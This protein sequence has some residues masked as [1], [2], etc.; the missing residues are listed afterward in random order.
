MS[1]RDL[2]RYLKINE[3]KIYKLVQEGKVP[4]MK[5]GGK[6]AFVRELIDK[7]ILGNTEWEQQLFV[8]GSDDILLRNIIDAY[9]SLHGGLVFYAP[10][11]SINGLKALQ[12]SKATMSCVHILESAKKE[13]D[14]S[15]LEK[16]LGGSEY[17]V[18]QLFLREQGLMVPKG[19]PKVI[20]SLQ[21]ITIKG[22]G[23]VNRNQGSGTR[24]LLDF[25]LREAKIEPMSLK[26]YGTEVDT[27]IQ[28][29]LSVLKGLADVG[30]GIRHVAHML[31]LDFVFLFKE[32]FDVVIP[33][34]R[35]YSSHVKAFLAFCEQSA[36]L[37]NV[38]DFTGYDLDKMG[39]VV[40]PRG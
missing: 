14:V 32:R 11:G 16:Y 8:A 7:W 36:L 26:G 38:R 31:G 3:K 5:I 23:F 28:V 20:K 35:Y 34:E 30:F 33:K 27:H 21:D 9:N 1:A 37:P 12:D 29:G 40:F 24:L 2:S 18:I 25:L 15:Y 13:E 4:S 17:F 22:A 10:V 6:I 19:N 39:K